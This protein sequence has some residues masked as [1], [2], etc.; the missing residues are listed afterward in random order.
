MRVGA[1]VLARDGVGRHYVQSVRPE[2][3]AAH[4]AGCGLASGGGAGCE[5]CCVLFSIGIVPTAACH[6]YRTIGGDWLFNTTQKNGGTELT[7]GGV[8]VDAWGGAV[9][10]RCLRRLTRTHAFLREHTASATL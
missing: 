3:A 5:W 6:Q 10:G 8:N 2:H 1:E 4:G 7:D 9:F